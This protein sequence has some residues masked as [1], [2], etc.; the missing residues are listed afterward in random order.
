MIDSRRVMMYLHDETKYR[1]TRRVNRD[2]KLRFATIGSLVSNKWEGWAANINYN[3]YTVIETVE[4]YYIPVPATSLNSICTFRDDTPINE[5]GLLSR[6]ATKI[7]DGAGKIVFTSEKPISI[8]IRCNTRY[9]AIHVPR[10][11]M[12]PFGS[13]YGCPTVINNARIKSHKASNGI[14]GDYIVCPVVGN[15]P[16]L[17]NATIVNGAVFCEDYDM[18]RF[19]VD[20]LKK[21]DAEFTKAVEVKE[22]YDY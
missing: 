7:R 8:K 9:A 20:T 18:T 17:S 2:A 16:D 5:A 19:N 12:L 6:G 21:A 14:S 1:L 13:K 15:K 11:I 10:S 22:R 3:N 4:G